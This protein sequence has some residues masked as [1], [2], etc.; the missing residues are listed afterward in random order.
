VHMAA[1]TLLTGMTQ[2]SSVVNVASAL[3]HRRVTRYV[4]MGWP[5]TT[6]LGLIAFFGLYA[7]AAEAGYDSAMDISPACHTRAS[8][9]LNANQPAVCGWFVNA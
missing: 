7:P 8:P 5:S 2:L 6:G 1:C 3:L 4:L 9:A